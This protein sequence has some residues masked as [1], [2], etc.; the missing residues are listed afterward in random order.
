[1]VLFIRVMGLLS[2]SCIA[3]AIRIAFY[4]CI[5]HGTYKQRMQCYVRTLHVV[6]VHFMSI[7]QVM[8]STHY[9]LC[10][11]GV[12]YHTTSYY[13]HKIYMDEIN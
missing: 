6:M 5:D 11:N 2:Y 8:N 13:L 10:P 7:C 3:L 1:M 12:I 4:D 9:G